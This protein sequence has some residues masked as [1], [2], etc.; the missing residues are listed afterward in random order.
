[1]GLQLVER[2]W[3]ISAL[4]RHTS[5]QQ[6]IRQGDL[7]WERGRWIPASASS[8]RVGRQEVDDR[9]S[10]IAIS[11]DHAMPPEYNR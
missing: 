11:L 1:M 2:D 10:I 4:D 8:M 5:K 3:S 9:A 6:I 7:T